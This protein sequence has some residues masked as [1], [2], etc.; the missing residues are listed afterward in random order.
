MDNNGKWL[1]IAIGAVVGGIVNGGLEIIDA[2]MKGEDVDWKKVG[3]SFAQG[4]LDGNLTK[5]EI[6]GNVAGAAVNSLLI[7]GTMV[8]SKLLGKV[9]PKIANSLFE[10]G[11]HPMLEKIASEFIAQGELDNKTLMWLAKY[12]ASGAKDAMQAAKIV[13]QYIGQEVTID[14]IY[15]RVTSFI[16]GKIDDAAG[17]CG[18]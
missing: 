8:G 4:A 6:I 15:N 16:D 1:N 12:A 7:G 11:K 18:N 14:T 17:V 10:S 9:A 3:L 2:K 13:A 5:N